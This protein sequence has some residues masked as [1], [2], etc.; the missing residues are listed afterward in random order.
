MGHFF[1]SNNT[2]TYDEMEGHINIEAYDN[3]Q[4]K[5]KSSQGKLQFRNNGA[6]T[7]TFIS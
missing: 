2:M 5:E 6:I 3:V 7:I 4:L 1:A